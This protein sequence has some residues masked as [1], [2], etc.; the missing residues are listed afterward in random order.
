MK[1]LN[2]RQLKILEKITT[3]ESV[4]SS[5]VFNLLNK[6][7]PL[8]TI[9]RDLNYLFSI[10][11]L[12]KL[13]RGPGTT[14]IKT[15][16]G[17]TLTQIDPTEYFKTEPDKRN[18]LERFNFSLFNDFPKKVFL[19]EEIKILEDATK[20]YRDK[21]K[22]ITP[23]IQKKELERFIIELSWK[24][25]KIE[26][27]TYTLLD[28]ERLLREGIPAEGHSEDEATMILNHKKAFCFVMDNLKSDI[29][30]QFIEKVHEL[31]INKLGVKKGIR[32]GMV[33][34]TGTKYKP[35][36]NK[37]QIK[38][39]LDSLIK[40][41]N[42]T[43]DPYSKALITLAGISYI[44]PFED[45]NKRVSRLVSNAILLSKDCAPL[46]YRNT[47]ENEYKKAM[48]IFYEKNSLSLIKQIFIDQYLFSTENYLV[49]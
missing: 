37:Y 20:M 40:L 14:Y 48:L 38:E 25:A 47:D 35:L 31:L 33:G 10:N 2:D 5:G 7:F 41:I 22:K 23:V 43:S 34:I 26:G 17:N 11:F 32:G 19:E 3:E 9:K 36:D 8:I 18:G 30:I 46:S 15:N 44:Q 42:S 21:I 4:S 24:S 27:N 13:G 1:P 45:G 29:N 28:A 39:A 16:L 12:K 6:E 49:D